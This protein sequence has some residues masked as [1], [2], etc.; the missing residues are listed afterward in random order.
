M[1]PIIS[2][3]P[4]EIWKAYENHATDRADHKITLNGKDLKL[5]SATRTAGHIFA[6]MAVTAGGEKIASY[7]T[8]T[9]K[10]QVD[11]LKREELTTH[12]TAM[13]KLYQTH[14]LGSETTAFRELLEEMEEKKA[15]LDSSHSQD[16]T[17]SDSN[18][19]TSSDRLS[20]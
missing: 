14:S 19:P 10:N 18:T 12:I 3:D 6:G 1:D 11:V 8:N 20:D 5:E 4:A 16:I 13:T 9:Y 15:E 17:N 2:K 7:V